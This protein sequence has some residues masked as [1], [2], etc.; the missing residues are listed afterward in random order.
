MANEH[1]IQARIAQMN[2]Q[3]QQARLQA[4]EL[5]SHTH[6]QECHQKG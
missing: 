2:T 4:E 3:V 1:Q 6:D 5:L